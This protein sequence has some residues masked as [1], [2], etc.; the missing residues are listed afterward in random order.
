MNKALKRLNEARALRKSAREVV[1]ADLSFIKVLMS[2]EQI[3]YRARY[4]AGR[5][6]A[7]AQ[8]LA[9]EASDFA[10][11]NPNAVAGGVAALALAGFALG[12]FSHRKNQCRNQD[13]EPEYEVELTA[14]GEYADDAPRKIVG[15]LSAGHIESE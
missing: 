4:D 3:A 9:D 10:R 7:K 14:E 15:E 6:K 11:A 5:L 13:E 1:E 8:N 2:P 12:V